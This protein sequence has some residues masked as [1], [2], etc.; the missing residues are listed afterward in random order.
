[1]VHFLSFKKLLV[2]ESPISVGSI[3]IKSAQSAEGQPCH[4]YVHSRM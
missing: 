1:M 4:I 3:Y 2:G